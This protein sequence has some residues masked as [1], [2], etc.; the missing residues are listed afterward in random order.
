M[1]IDTF[2]I[3]SAGHAGVRHTEKRFELSAAGTVKF[4]VEATPVEG[5]ITVEEKMH[6]GVESGSDEE[7][8]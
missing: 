6:C 8:E 1:L 2:T 5:A 3:P 4:V 7:V